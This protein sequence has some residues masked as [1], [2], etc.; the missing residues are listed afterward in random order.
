MDRPDQIEALLYGQAG[1][2]YEKLKDD[3]PVSLYQEYL[4]LKEK[5]KLT[6]L[7]PKIWKFLRMR[8]FN[9]PS[10][11]ISQFARLLHSSSGL[12]TKIL[13]H[14]NLNEIYSLF[15]VEGSGYWQDHSRFDKVCKPKSVR[16]GKSSVD[17]IMINTVIPFSFTYGK[18]FKREDMQDKA[19]LW[20]EKIKPEKNHVT[21][22]FSSL[23]IEIDN[24]KQSQALIQLKKNYCDKKRCL[25]CRF[26]HLLI[27]GKA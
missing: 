10:V 7:D 11:R 4:F 5:Y 25:E 9:F 20:Y 16:L 1:M 26:G 22:A 24:A 14:D 27:S 19:L 8:P 21:R 6:P 18:L 15:S 3:Y 13:E 17:L 12:L 2:L 23:G